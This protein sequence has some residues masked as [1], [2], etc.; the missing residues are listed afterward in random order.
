MLHTPATGRKRA[1]CRTLLL[2]LVLAVLL[3]LGAAAQAAAKLNFPFTTVSTVNVN[4]R[5]TASARGTILTT[6]RAGARVTVTG[7]SGSYFQ[8]TYNGK[9]GYI[10]KKYLSTDAGDLITP[11]P[12]EA[13]VVS[14]YPYETVTRKTVNLRDGR[15]TRSGLLKKVPAGA[16]VTVKNVTGTWAEVT[17]KGTDGY[18][19]T[20][21]LVIK[22]VVK[23]T[24]TPKPTAT[25]APEESLE[26][27][28]LLKRGDNGDGVVSL[29]NA[30]IELGYLNGTADGN[31]G[32]A[33]ES[34]LLQLQDKNGYPL[35]GTAD[36][37]LQAFLFNGKPKN[38]RGEKT[39][40][41]ELP[42]IEGATITMNKRGPLVSKVQ[43][44]LKE[45]GFYSG[46]YTGVYDK[47]T[48]SAVTAFQKKNGMKGD[49]VCDLKTQN[50]LFSG[51]GMTKSQTAT[52]K[53]TATPSPVPTF[54][55]PSGTVNSKST[56]QDARLVQKRLKELGYY[57]GAVDGKFGT[58]SVK[59]LKAFQT[60]HGL[61][62]DGVAGKGTYEIMFSLRAL[63][64]GATPTPEPTATPTPTP[65][66]T[67][68]PAPTAMTKENTQT[69]RQGS[70]GDAVLRL[71]KRLEALGYYISA[72]DGV[73]KA[74]DVA[75][76]KLFQKTNGLKADGVAGFD[77][78]SRLYS[79]GAITYSGAMAAGTVD[80]FQTLRRGSSGSDVT[81]LQERLSA[82]GYYKDKA[83][84][85][86]GAATVT[87]VTAF[88]RAN[89]LVRDGVAGSNTLT[90]IYSAAAVKAAAATAT[91]KPGAKAEPEVTIAS[92][93]LKRGD[94]SQA[95]KTMQER[96]VALGYLTGK[97][98]GRFGVATYNA[99]KAFQKA[100][101]L[102][103]DGVAGQATLTALNSKKAVS[104]EGGTLATTAPAL[105]PAPA[106]QAASQT[107]QSTPKASQVRYANWYSE[108]KSRCASYPYVTV[109]DYSSG[110]S[111]QMHMFSLGKHA[112]VE[113]L[114]ASDTAKMQR[115]LGGTTWNPKAVWV[116]FADGRVY[117]ASIHSYAHGVQHIT[118][119]NFG[120]H[121]CIHFP[122]TAAQVE[123][124]GVYATRHQAT[125]D[126]GWEATQA[127]AK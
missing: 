125:I 32:S 98:D 117:M 101:K 64:A 18:M 94:N 35:S 67:A 34:A 7:E 19:K 72:G 10:L 73:C 102:K 110:I 20:D 26:S 93:T 1:A 40:V 39:A 91:P 108:V 100:N 104:V 63:K 11:V 66:P 69:L 99:L 3:S 123:A 31:F 14:A 75:A 51:T 21:Y 106:A 115:A 29:Q 60:A 59:A 122:R 127:M 55:I 82:L 71:Q 126:K 86:Y 79:A 112:D 61:A 111:W 62:A 103:S 43:I 78:Q 12:Q 85:Y 41:K 81:A 4:M 107:S 37:N 15:S 84:G 25:P 50:L 105:T 70:S 68:T 47:A 46:E 27:Y 74:D 28:R 13:E 88:Q 52:P 42:P 119:N 23:P 44:V 33:T 48:R 96:L 76:I 116:V 65:K 124:I 120:G 9:N 80:S 22:K 8:V 30:L 77:T 45:L 109:Y 92:T 56:G 24:R 57:K 95:V 38:S 97:A 53:P 2:G 58:G 5:R 36:A 89:G 121:C 49:G 114:T 17:Y 54:T 87:A 6:V 113:P 83:D 118:T 90:K 16:S